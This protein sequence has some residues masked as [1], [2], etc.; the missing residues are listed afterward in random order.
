M[1][2]GGTDIGTVHCKEEEDMQMDN[3]S[4]LGDRERHVKVLSNMNGCYV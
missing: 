1:C 2:A 4:V 3:C